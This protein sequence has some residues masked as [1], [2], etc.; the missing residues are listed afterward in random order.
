MWKWMQRANKVKTKIVLERDLD[1]IMAV[2][3]NTDKCIIKKQKSFSI[4][5]MNYQ[6]MRVYQNCYT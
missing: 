1:L 4:M 5:K 2:T 6:W 3:G